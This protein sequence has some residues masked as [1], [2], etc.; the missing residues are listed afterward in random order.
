MKNYNFDSHKLIYHLDRVNDFI[1]NGDCFPLYLEISPVGSCNHRCIF[2][3]YDFIG[4]PNRKL[5]TERTLSLLD[6]LA[7]VGIKSILFAG[8]GEPLLHPDIARLISHAASNG[9]NVGLFTNGQLLKDDLSAAIL[10]HLTFLR[11]SFN[12]GSPGNYAQIHQVKPEVFDSVVENIAVACRIKQSRSLAVDIGTQFVLI[13]ENCDFLLDAAKTL[14]SAGVDYLAIK[15]FVQQSSQQHY[16]VG[17]QLSAELVDSLLCEVE[18]LACT[19]FSVMARRRAFEDYG[20]RGYQ[21]CYGSSFI[22]V[23]NSAGNLST[24]L[25]YW[26]KEEFVF[27]NIYEHSFRE[28][29]ASEQRSKIL[30]YLQERLD[31]HHCPPNCRTNEVNEFLW[32][33]KHPNVKHINFI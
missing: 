5:E 8:E 10:P 32:D 24:C 3:A 7:K 25:P 20:R 4:Y 15:P 33:L 2:C 23:L 16:Q 13:P 21:H 1:T 31:T 6:E 17:E 26:D 30:Q 11:L 22:S 9:I 14:K 29:W 27:G 19:G 18:A 28:I 12:G